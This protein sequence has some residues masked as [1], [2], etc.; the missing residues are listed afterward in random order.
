MTDRAALYRVQARRRRGDPLPLADLDGAGTSL[1]DVLAALLDGFA[2]TSPDGA[3][4]ARVLSVSST[5]EEVFAV[6]QHGRRGVAAD[7]VGPTGA[8][9]LR[10]H[11]DDLQLVRCGCLF[12]LPAT[13]TEGTLAVQLAYGRGVKDLFEQGLAARFAARLPGLTLA[14]DRLAD[15]D[16]LRRAVA[17]DRVERVQLVRVEPP[18]KRG[19][20]TGKWVPQSETA[21]VELEVAVQGSGTGLG[22]QLLGR[23]LGGEAGAFAEIVAF[24]GLTFDTAKIGVRMPDDSRRLVDLEH[25]DAGRPATRALEGIATDRAGEPTDASLLTALR[26]AVAE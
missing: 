24:G 22:R 8:L 25:P 1:A 16:T 21:R 17:E 9:R 4:A 2:E 6:V 5:N 3:R 19:A 15:P 18:G 13:A 10:Q 7:I 20:E 11:P 26:K 23:Y 14:L 12:R